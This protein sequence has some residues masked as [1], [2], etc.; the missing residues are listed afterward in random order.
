MNYKFKLASGDDDVESC[1]QNPCQFGGKCI[2]NGKINR[3]QCQ[4]HYTGR[5][6]ALNMCEVEPCLFG[7]CELT[8]TS[9]KVI[10]FWDIFKNHVEFLFYNFLQ[11]RCHQGYIGRTCDQKQKPCA[12]KPCEAR[13]E[14][15]DRSGTFFCRFLDLKDKLYECFRLE[16]CRSAISMLY[17]L[18]LSK[19]SRNY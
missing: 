13:G 5:F 4:G 16:L 10:K 1:Q 11:C 15:F 17:L 9:F 12:E 14:C 18:L 3:C 6:C 7:K 2:S 8:E 19:Y